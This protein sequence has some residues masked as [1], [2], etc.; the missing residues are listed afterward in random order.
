MHLMTFNFT[1]ND[2]LFLHIC[3]VAFFILLIRQDSMEKTNH[4]T[5][6]T[7]DKTSFIPHHL[8]NTSILWLHTSLTSHGFFL[9]RHGT[10]T[11][12]FHKLLVLTCCTQPECEFMHKYGCKCSDTSS[13]E[14]HFCRRYKNLKEVGRSTTVL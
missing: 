8:K 12:Q 6:N 10:Y 4:S 9:Q 11:T 1:A 5:L 2:T 3:K 14:Y 13:R 7:Q